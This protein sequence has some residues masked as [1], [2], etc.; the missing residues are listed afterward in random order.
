MNENSLTHIISEGKLELMSGS[1]GILRNCI[2]DI[3]WGRDAGHGEGFSG[4]VV[5]KFTQSTAIWSPWVDSEF[6][7]ATP[8]LL[9]VEPGR[10]SYM[11]FQCSHYAPSARAHQVGVR[12]TV[13]K[14]VSFPCW[15]NRR[16]FILL[17]GF[18]SDRTRVIQVDLD[19]PS[20]CLILLSSH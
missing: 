10:N 5:A 2:F 12:D 16:T 15:H 4:A 14:T 20:L 13:N 17:L 18:R 9:S 6:T 8:P 7:L 3:Y 11:N 19:P 1:L